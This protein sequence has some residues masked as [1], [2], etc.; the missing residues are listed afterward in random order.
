M[1]SSE[2]YQV[3][4]KV[5]L[6]GAF[7][8]TLLGFIKVIIG[9]KGQSNA[10]VADGLH[11]FSDLLSDAFVL[12]ASRFGSEE[13]DEAHP[14]GHQRIETAATLFISLLLIFVGAGIIFDA[15][16]TI[17]SHHLVLSKWV[18]LAV[19]ISI[20]SNE[21]LYHYTKYFAKKI[22]SDLLLANAWHHRSDAISS[23]IV[24]IGVLGEWFGFYAFDEIAAIIVALMIIKM[25]VKLTWNS[26]KELIDTGVDEN[27]L[28]QIKHIIQSTPSV[29]ALHELR[30]RFMAGGVFVDVHLIVSP[31]I[32]VS[33]GHQIGQTVLERLKKE[34]NF[35]KDVTV[36]ID[37]EDD[38]AYRLEKRQPLRDELENHLKDKWQ[39]IKASEYVK[40]IN[41]HYLNGEIEADIFFNDDEI[42]IKSATKELKNA[43]DSDGIISRLRFYLSVGQ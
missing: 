38:E 43:L 24:L 32:S 29:M 33:E 15:L 2:R 34:T 19:L 31:Y 9:V 26:L 39:G 12:I 25:G 13:A 41:F 36:H 40:N 10:L 16:L 27:K 3:A 30:T 1:S 4:K 28:S 37:A 42:D 20:F 8:N 7:I 5:T 17:K 23:F 11:S 35:I 14:Y 18:L 6:V 21:G 22:H